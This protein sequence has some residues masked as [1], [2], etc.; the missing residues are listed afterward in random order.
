MLFFSPE[1]NLKTWLAFYS[2]CHRDS[3]GQRRMASAAHAVVLSMWQDM[4]G[5]GILYFSVMAGVMKAKVCART[6]TP[7]ISVSILGMWQA[8]H[9]LPAELSLGTKPHPIA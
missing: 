9:A 7:G 3:S 8:T 6:K 1:R 4:H 2:I 5:F